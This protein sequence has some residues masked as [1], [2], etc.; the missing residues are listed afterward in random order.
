MTTQLQNK[1]T[2][3]K[4]DSDY[5]HPIRDTFNVKKLKE[6]SETERKNNEIIDPKIPHS[7][8]NPKINPVDIDFLTD[9]FNT[10]ILG[11]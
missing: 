5:E 8:F 10:M 3:T 1:R 7:G 11:K 9:K 2:W 6:T 4:M